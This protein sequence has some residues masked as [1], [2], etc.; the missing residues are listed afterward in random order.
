MYKSDT[1]DKSL[2]R[3]LT[4][5]QLDCML[6]VRGG[7]TSKQIARE[8][9]ISP[10]TVDQH[11]AAALEVLQ[12][13]NRIAAISRMYELEQKDGQTR[14]D[15]A[16]MLETSAREDETHI[17]VR[18]NRPDGAA[19]FPPLGGLQNTASH[20]T[21]LTWIVRIAIFCVMLTCIAVLAIMGV[22]EMVS[23]INR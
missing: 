23:S 14:A 19:I 10:R 17:L 22:S 20:K 21:R 5:R 9:G 4:G 12:V 15:A 7:C 16:F 2:S 3:T 1:S 18:E 11:I 13:S 6:L 8:L